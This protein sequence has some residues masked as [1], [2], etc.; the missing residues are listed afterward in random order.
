MQAP[1]ATRTN[2]TP[3]TKELVAYRD[4]DALET[5]F[6]LNRVSVNANENEQQLELGFSGIVD[7]LADALIY[8]TAS[9][10]TGTTLPWTWINTFQTR[11]GGGYGITQGASIGTAPTRTRIIEQDASLLD[12][13][14]NLSETGT[15]FDFAINTA[16]QWVEYHST[17]GTDNGVV[18]QYGMNVRD[19]SW[20]ESTAPGELVTDVRVYGQGTSGAPRT[21]SDSAARTTYGRRE[22]SLTYTSEAENA[23]TS[24]AQLQQFADASLERT[25]PLVIPQI[26]LVPNHPMSPFGSYWL[27]D[28]ITFQ[29][30]IGSFVNIDAPYRIVAIHID[31]DAEDNETIKLDLN[32]V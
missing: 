29:A 19:F 27:G 8:G 3:G 15:G 22:A 2:L 25:T 13:I 11:T 23:V 17:R 32:A 28:S 30:K 1:E 31:L 16:R 14:I 12:E 6:A 18:L 24:A 21:A 9:A 4:G 7:Y 26:E 5:I 20:E 10:H